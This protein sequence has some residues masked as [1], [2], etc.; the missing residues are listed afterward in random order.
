VL[1]KHTPCPRCQSYGRLDPNDS[2]S[3]CRIYDCQML[4]KFPFVEMSSPG[5][6]LLTTPIR[7]S[8]KRKRNS[9]RPDS[10]C[11]SRTATTR[12]YSQIVGASDL[13]SPGRIAFGVIVAPH[14]GPLAE[15]SLTE[16]DRSGL[17]KT[18]DN[19]SV[20]WNN[21]ADESPAACCC[22]HVVFRCDVILDGEGYAM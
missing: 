20:A 2:I 16:E 1:R 14:V 21:A 12:V 8:A 15:P 3:L 17:S 4:A 5:F 22:L 10:C 6:G 13:S 9:I 7:L 19:V 18:G 11:T